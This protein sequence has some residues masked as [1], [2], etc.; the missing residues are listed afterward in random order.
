MKRFKNQVILSTSIIYSK[1]L[2]ITNNINKK[3]RTKS[4]SQ[5]RHRDE[6]FKL[7]I[8]VLLLWKKTTP[9]E[10]VLVDQ[11]IIFDFSINIFFYYLQSKDFEKSCIHEI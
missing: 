11:Y 3:K 7:K 2:N 9:S 4:L 10:T 6:F 8:N 1:L 5:V